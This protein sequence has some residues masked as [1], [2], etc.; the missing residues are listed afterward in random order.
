MTNLYTGLFP[1]KGF[2]DVPFLALNSEEYMLGR[3]FPL[4]REMLPQIAKP[5]VF[6]IRKSY[7]SL[8]PPGG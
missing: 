5:A 7:I 6:L 1:W 3:E 8:P 2:I 4:F